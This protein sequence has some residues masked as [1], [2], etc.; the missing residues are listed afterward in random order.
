[1]T[2]NISSGNAGHFAWFYQRVTGV[3]L[4]P[5]LYV[6]YKVNHFSIAGGVGGYGA[7]TY[8][9]VAAKL[10]DPFWKAFDILFV[11]CA[12]YHA[13]NGLWIIAADYLHKENHRLVVYGTLWTVGVVAMIAMLIVIVPFRHP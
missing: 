4:I 5:L 11:A 12:L 8:A 9:E 2:K 7:D 13:L 3:I 6:H 10:A 1:M